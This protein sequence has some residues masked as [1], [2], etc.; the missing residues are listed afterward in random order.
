MQELGIPE[1][2][3]GQPDSGR[4]GKWRAFDWRDG[5]GGRNT[6]QVTGRPGVL[7][8]YPIRLSPLPPPRKSIL[9]PRFPRASEKFSSPD[10]TLL[11]DAVDAVLAPSKAIA[12]DH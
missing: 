6:T 9:S 3:N 10:G 11:R 2:M 5:E 8:S 4:D 1:N 7:M 12:Y